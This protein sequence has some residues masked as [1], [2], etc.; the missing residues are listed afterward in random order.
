MALSLSV[1]N[2]EKLPFFCSNLI[3]IVSMGVPVDLC[4]SFA[5]FCDTVYLDLS[6]LNEEYHE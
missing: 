1:M 5:N 6:N 4:L 3:S 2:L